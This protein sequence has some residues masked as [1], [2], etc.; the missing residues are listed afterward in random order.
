LFNYAH[1]A[2]S[3]NCYLHHFGKR[4]SL[5]CE[6]GYGKET[7]TLSVG[8]P[9]LQGA[10]ETLRKNVGTRRKR[11]RMLLGNVKMLKHTV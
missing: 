1:D 4:N 10:K 2:V 5:N 7:G 6:C 9:E 8:M 3:L 11:V